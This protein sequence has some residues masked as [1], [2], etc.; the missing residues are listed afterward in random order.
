M[1]AISSA[2]T[3]IINIFGHHNHTQVGQNNSTA[4]WDPPITYPSVV[5]DG[6]GTK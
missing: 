6:Q 3:K 1:H 4:S 2:K 5:D